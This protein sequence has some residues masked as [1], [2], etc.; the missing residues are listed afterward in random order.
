M[1]DQ[2]ILMKQVSIPLAPK[3]ASAYAKARPEEQKKVDYL[4]NLWL[5]NIFS[6]RRNI[7]DKLFDT[8]EQI[9]KIAAA[10]GLTPEILQDILNEKS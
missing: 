4:V 2:N 7:N 3:V 1:K 6:G 10:N 8:M 9:G 5:K